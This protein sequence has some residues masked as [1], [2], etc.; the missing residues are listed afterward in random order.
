MTSPVYA[1]LSVATCYSF[2]RGASHAHELVGTARALGLSAMAVTDRNT[3]SGVVKA[4]VAARACGLPL[5]IGARLV[6]EDGFPEVLAYA[7]NRAAYG[8]LSRLITHGAMRDDALKGQCRLVFEDLKAHAEGLLLALVPPPRPDAGLL[9]SLERLVDI[10][11]GRVWLAA[12]QDYGA[13]D[14]RRLD[15]LALQAGQAGVSLLAVNDVVYHDAG[16]RPLHDVMSCIREHATLAQ[17]GPR[18]LSNGERRLKSPAEMAALFRDYPDAIRQTEALAGMC[19]FSLDELKY[20]YP[21]EPVP[22]GTTPQAYL[23]ALTWSGARWRYPAGIPDKVSL[24]LRSEFELIAQKDYACYFLT[25]HDVVRFARSRNILCQGRG[26]AANSAVCFCLGVTAVDPTEHA[27]LFARFISSERDEPPDIDVDFEHERREEVIQYIYERYGRH[28]AAICATVIHYRPRSAIREVGKAFGLSEDV[29]G[30]LAGMVWGAWGGPPPEEHIRQAGLDPANPLIAQAVLMTCELLGFPRHLSQHVGGFVLTEG[31]LDETVPV[32]NAA[33]PD[34]T[35]IEWD[36]DDIDALGLMKVDVLALGMLTCIRK[37]FALLDIRE[38]ADIPQEDPAVYDML[39]EADSVGVFQVESRAQMSM[40]PRLRPRTFYDLVIEVAIVRPGPIQGDMVHPYLRRR[41]G[42]ETPEL[43]GPAGGDPDELKKVL[44]RTMGVP[45]FQEQA[46]QIAITAAGFSPSQADGLR[47]AMATFRNAGTIDLYRN[48]LVEGMVGRGYERDFAERCF[49]Q[50][51]GFGSYGLPESHAASFAKLVYVSSWLKRHHPAAFCC[52]IL[53]SQPMGFYAPAQLVRDAR[54][55][56]VEVRPVDVEASQWDGVLEYPEAMEAMEIRNGGEGGPAVRLG[57]RQ[58][59]GFSQAWAERLTAGR[60]MAG[61]AFGDFNRFVRFCGLTSAQ[62]LRLAD[63]DAL[64]S[65]GLDRREALWKIK[66]L[67]AGG[68]APLLAQLPDEEALPLLPPMAASE[69]VV[70]DYQSQHLSLRDHP[71]RF[72]REGFAARRALPCGR[73]KDMRDRD[74]GITAGVVLVRQRPGGGKVCFITLEDET[75]V[76]NLVVMPEVFAR[77]RKVIM[78]S[79]LMLAEGRIQRSPEGIVHLLCHRLVDHSADLLRL[80]EPAQ[81]D[82]GDLLV[83]ADEVKRGQ[84]AR[85]PRTSHPRNV[86]ILPRSRD[87]H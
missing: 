77:H 49:K 85:P 7:P 60:A 24:A 53:N 19:G 36:K 18:L 16:R 32:V 80:S 72:L 20:E 25:V 66:G 76:A 10:A 74:R 55:H 41:Q 64:R 27:L 37:A 28:R 3:L 35:F 79:R 61:G 22:A 8:R 84:D 11:P 47:R 44:G 83:A 5:V 6:F 59:D 73:L 54:E 43:P 78:T 38:L 4:H 71:M 23:E 45:L 58:I 75:G 86:R 62:M 46:M 68:P 14:V 40:L 29:T 21:N 65:L 9:R 42:V 56:G 67:E 31:R 1:E 69:H 82:F 51:E 12:A 48:L 34:R 26:S 33:M 2:L 39:C 63:A 57:F 13:L 87:F 15:Q 17:A 30:A 81:L 70:A 50:I 52:A